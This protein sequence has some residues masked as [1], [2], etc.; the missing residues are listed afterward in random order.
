MEKKTIQ[1]EWKEFLEA[2]LQEYL[3]FKGDGCIPTSNV[4]YDEETDPTEEGE[5]PF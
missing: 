4:A 2:E 3:V 1:Q 5:M